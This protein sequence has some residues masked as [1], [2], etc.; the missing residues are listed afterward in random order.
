MTVHFRDQEK[1]AE[2][3]KDGKWLVKLDALKTG[4]PDELTIKG[5]NTLTIKDVLVGE[6][7]VGSGQS[8]MQISVTGF[9]PKDQV[10]E[11]NANGTLSQKAARSISPG[12]ASGFRSDT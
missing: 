4:G 7:W 1:T 6:V 12:T 10:L 3:G 2:A 11:A 9:V 8:N 5:E